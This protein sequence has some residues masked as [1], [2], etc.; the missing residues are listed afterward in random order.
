MS[1]SSIIG[2]HIA[3][4]VILLVSIAA[5]F[6]LIQNRQTVLDQV[7][8]W[9]YQPSAEI[10][11]LAD[12]TEMTDQGRRTFYASR[13]SLEPAQDF[14]AVCGNNEQGTAVLGCY[15]NRQIYIYN[16]TDR[17]LDGIR[18]VTAAHEMLHAVYERM[19]DAERNQVNKL[20]DA[21]YQTLSQDSA[22]ADRM[23]YYAK[24]EPGERNNELHSIIGTEVAAISPELEAH[25][26]RY[27]SNRAAVIALHDKYS[28]VF[29][30]L[31]AQ[32]ET[33]SN[34]LDVLATSIEQATAA[35]NEATKQL[36][37]DINSFNRR[38][39]AGEFTS[40]S[41]FA[42]E[43]QVL[44]ARSQDLASDRQSISNMISEYNQLRDQL[45]AIATQTEA[46]NRSID[47]SLAPAPSL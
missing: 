5:A 33:L 25:Y 16:V 4:S 18:D 36:N 20:L 9:Q 24:V 27:F 7:S 3:S 44:A 26:R 37:S 12:R 38:A 22:F 2:Q 1:R 35:Y 19:P 15:A 30:N 39:S 45:A 6:L 46:L 8:L 41:Q 43:R 29:S 21:E 32:S 40:Q 34:R 23:A 11:G 17:Q 31:K 14:Q 47:S 28:S 42:A 10:A 13:P